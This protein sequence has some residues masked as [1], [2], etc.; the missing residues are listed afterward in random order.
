M[1]DPRLEYSPDPDRAWFI[2][3]TVTGI[4]AAALAALA[5]VTW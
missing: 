1:S 5:A 2:I 4:L 3:A